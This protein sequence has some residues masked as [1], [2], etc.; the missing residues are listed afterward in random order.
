M[1]E[2][3]VGDHSFLD[4][5]SSLDIDFPGILLKGSS[6]EFDMRQLWLAWI[7]VDRKRLLSWFF[8]LLVPS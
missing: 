8:K 6:H 7:A 5:G 2:S 1:I 3:Y 4:R